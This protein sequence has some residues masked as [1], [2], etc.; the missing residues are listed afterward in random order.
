M[1][2]SSP[3]V[4]NKILKK[5]QI[6]V[7]KIKVYVLESSSILV[8]SNRCPYPENCEGHQVDHLHYHYRIV[9]FFEGY[10]LVN[11]IASG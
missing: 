1:F 3:Q 6:R 4:I 7:S 10:Y 8:A 5:P 9:D 2:M 11:S